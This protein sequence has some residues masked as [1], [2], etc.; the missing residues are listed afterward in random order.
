MWI[1]PPA[2]MRWRQR[3]W[4]M[5]TVTSIGGWCAAAILSISRSKAATV[6]AT[7]LGCVVVGFVQ[8]PPNGP[9]S[10]DSWARPN[11]IRSSGGCVEQLR[12]GRS[13]LHAFPTGVASARATDP[14]APGYPADRACG[15]RLPSR[16]ARGMEAPD[17]RAAVERASRSVRRW[18]PC[19][20]CHTMT[21]PAN[22]RPTTGVQ[23]PLGSPGDRPGERA[24]RNGRS[25]AIRVTR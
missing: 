9:D 13:A 16:N 12:R 6:A 23:P 17:A 24:A 20:S 18:F 4:A 19:R 8:L 11:Y 10:P 2:A 25:A 3:S 21:E 22:E 1:S 15:D 5:E 7:S 14:C